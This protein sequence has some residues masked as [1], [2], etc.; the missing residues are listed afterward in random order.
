MSSLE[1][2]RL[3]LAPAAFYG[4][5]VR[6]L[7]VKSAFLNGEIV[8][9]IYVKQS[10]GYEIPRKEHCFNRLKKA[11]YELKQAPR[12]WYSKLDISLLELGL[13][14]SNHE[15]VV[16][17]SLSNLSKLY[18]GVYADDLLIAGNN[19][20]RISKFKD[21]MKVLFDMTDLGLL[22]SYLGIQVKRIKGKITLAQS[23]FALK[24]LS[25]FN[26]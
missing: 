2:I 22:K 19:K 17:Y 20:A 3:L 18:V 12:A 1:T 24:I 23:T 5:E 11:M 15:L 8:E 21:K 10:E 7:D 6:H 16:Y 25:D 13:N 26:L 14:R 4:W 9:E